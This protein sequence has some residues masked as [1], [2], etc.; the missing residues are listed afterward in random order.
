M[1]NIVVNFWTY[2]RNM[3]DG[4]VSV[5]CFNTREQAEKFAEPDDQRSCEDIEEHVLQL[6]ENTLQI[7][8]CHVRDP[9]DYDK[10]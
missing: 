2:A 3:G 8:N 7:M 1:K 5:Y 6:D 9:E 4:D 10:I